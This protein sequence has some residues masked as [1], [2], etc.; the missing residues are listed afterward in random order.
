MIRGPESNQNLPYA[1]TAAMLTG[2]LVL[3]GCQSDALEPLTQSA[4][5]EGGSIIHY[6]GHL[7]SAAKS[8]ICA[9]GSSMRHF[10]PPGDVTYNLTE[11]A[12]SH[13]DPNTDEVD[14]N[15]SDMSDG[16]IA[17]LVTRHELAHRVYALKLSGTQLGRLKAA[18]DNIPSLGDMV[19]QRPPKGTVWWAFAE[20]TYIASSS[21]DGHP[22]DNPNELFASGVDTMINFG[23]RVN[24]RIN[25]LTHG[26]HNPARLAAGAI[27]C[28]LQSASDGSSEATAQLSGIQQTFAFTSQEAPC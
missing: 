25:R 10:L 3:S 14:L 19:V 24:V 12:D 15:R 22:Q 20:S 16:T 21:S 26:R 18:Y 2:A 7:P 27:L 5:C 6:A 9:V 17:P 11:K 13:Y 23:P 1:L 28:A 4:A 8:T